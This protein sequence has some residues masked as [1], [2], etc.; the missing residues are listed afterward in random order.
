[1]ARIGIVILN[2]ITWKETKRC[3]ESIKEAKTKHEFAIYV[4]DN[5][6]PKIEE[7]REICEK[8][9]V[10]LIVN[11]FNIGYAAGNN[12]GIKRCLQ[13]GCDYI[14]ISN[15][16]IVFKEESI[17]KLCEF[18]S[19]HEEC[20]IVAPKI[21]DTEGNVQRCHFKKR[22]Q[23]TDI[24]NTQTIFRFLRKRQVEKVYGT[25]NFYKKNQELYASSGCCF[26]MSRRCAEEVT[27]LDEKT[28]LYEEENIL[29]SKMEKKGW[30]TA[31]I[32]DAEVI[33]NHNQTGRLVKP[34]IFVCWACSEIY[35][36]F[37]YL[38]V[39]KIK[40]WLLYLYRTVIFLLHAIKNKEFRKQ[41]KY[42]CKNTQKY[43]KKQW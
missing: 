11:A 33:H 43:L 6:S 22:M 38:N 12:V 3:I 30:K 23:Y 8:E 14:L 21:L 10:T 17:D 27:P 29:G 19:K 4:V 41:W 25:E 24:W 1:M 7:L 28:F 20:G 5:A 9:D 34:F 39:A 18:L 26:M 37:E 2:Y 40:V 32:V 35:Y 16:D 15:N 31:Y 13:D 42:Y 36:C